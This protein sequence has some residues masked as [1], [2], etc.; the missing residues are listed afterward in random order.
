VI[1]ARSFNHIGPGQSTDYVVAALAARMT[2]AR[3][4]GR[5]EISV[6]NLEARRDLT[7]VRDVVRAYRLLVCHGVPG[8]VYNVCSGRDVS[9]SEVADRLLEMVGDDLHLVVDPQLVRPVDLPVLRGDSTRLAEAT[10]WEPVHLLGDTLRD[11]LDF[12]GAGGR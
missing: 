7:D 9:I 6:G 3:Q 4:A 10:G 1:R 11:I 2:E 8:E 5:H 12:Q